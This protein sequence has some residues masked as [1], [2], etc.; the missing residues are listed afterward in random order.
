M[1]TALPRSSAQIPAVRARGDTVDPPVLLA[2]GTRDDGAT[3]DPRELAR[4]SVRRT[5]SEIAEED[6]EKSAIPEAEH[7]RVV[8]EPIAVPA[9]QLAAALPPRRAMP[10]RLSP[11]VIARAGV[12]RAT[13]VLLS[14][15]E[16]QR[17]LEAAMASPD[18]GIA[19]EVAPPPPVPAPPI[20]PRAERMASPAPARAETID[21]D[22]PPRAYDDG[23]TEDASTPGTIHARYLRN[24]RWVAIRIGSLSLKGAS[25]MA[26]A[27]PRIDD[28]V[29]IALLYGKLRALVRGAVAKVSTTQEAIASGA[30]AFHVS[31]ELDDASRRQ[32]TGLLTAARA[33]KVTIKPP[34]ARGA[35]RFQVEWPVCLG[36]IRGAVRADALDVS[37]DGMFVRPLHALALDANLAFTVVL[38]DGLPPVS[39]RSRV[40]RNISEADARAVGLS[41][42]YGLS[43]VD[44]AAPDRLRWCAFLARI[45]KRAS[46]RVLICAAPARL[47]EL[48]G[49]LVS[50]GYAA[51]GG[52]DPGAIAQLASAEARTVDAALIDAGWLAAS[53]SP[54]WVESLFSARNVPCVTMHGDARRARIAIDRLLSVA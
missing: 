14:S 10:P 47:A 23:P 48:Q 37:A 24:G 32:L 25:L 12:H 22:E 3:A 21:D 9:R 45:E 16:T 35:R 13:T 29:D 8:S 30:T 43:I 52:S 6:T 34:A 36:T 27:L 2:K 19:P 54:A 50:A 20:L 7:K 44:M 31:F 53:G 4:G 42:G 33:D 5:K 28:R 1:A 17:I 11:N 41:P 15:S 18:H 26:V 46:R 38:D 40:I 39:G 49:G 51:T